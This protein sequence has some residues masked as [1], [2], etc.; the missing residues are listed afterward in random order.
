[1]TTKIEALLRSFNVLSNQ[2]IDEVLAAGKYRIIKKNDFFIKQGQICREVAIVESGFF[3]SFY[4]NS[5]EDE[6]TYCFTF[7]NNFISAYSSFI[8]QENTVEN[9]HALSDAKIFSLP[10]SK[11]MEWERTSVN[12]LRLS[13]ILAEQEFIKMETRVFSLLK[14]NAEN[15][16]LELLNKHPEYL[17]FIPLNQ[18][19]SYLGITQRH[20]SRIRKEITF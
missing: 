4:Q 13:K 15:K 6:V 10:R 8:T 17:K 16:Y 19:A 7:S 5:A 9:I 3:R 1:M 11:I 14:E 20:L 12:W 2:E 18:L